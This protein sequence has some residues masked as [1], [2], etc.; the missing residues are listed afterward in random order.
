ME[1]GPRQATW[2]KQ[3]FGMKVVSADGK[4]ITKMQSVGRFLIK[5]FMSGLFMMI[6]FIMAAFTDRKQALHDLAAGTIVIQSR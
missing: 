2:G 1:T 5:H 6:G 4:R 3:V